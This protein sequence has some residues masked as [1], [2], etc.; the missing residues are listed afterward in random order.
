MQNRSGKDT[1]TRKRYN[2]NFRLRTGRFIA[3]VVS[4]VIGRITADGNMRVTADG[5][6]RVIPTI[7]MIF[8]RVTADGNV[9]I[10]ADGNVRIVNG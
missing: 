3:V 5:N 10:T 1:G 2:R 9:R 8:T 6:V 7:E 4:S